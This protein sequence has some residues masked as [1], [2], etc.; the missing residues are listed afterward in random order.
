MTV[1]C[2]LSLPGGLD[3]FYSDKCGITLE[4]CV[5]YTWHFADEEVYMPAAKGRVLHCFVLLSR[6]NR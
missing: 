3:L 2:G 5:P 6:D 4:P 1:A